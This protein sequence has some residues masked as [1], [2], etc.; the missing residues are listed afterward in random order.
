MM[1][2][3]EQIDFAGARARARS[4]RNS[5]NKQ[6]RNLARAFL[7]EHRRLDAC[8]AAYAHV[9]EAIVPGIPGPGGAA[10][11]AMMVELMRKKQLDAEQE[12]R[13]L[14]A[15]IAGMR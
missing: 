11:M 3:G 13:E 2:D 4:L 7:D 10:A 9:C 8:E 1:F 12:V 14:K 15:R 5:R 6:S